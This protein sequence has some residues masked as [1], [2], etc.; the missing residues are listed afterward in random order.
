MAFFKRKRTKSGS[1]WT[2][3][4][5]GNLTRS[6][7][8]TKGRQR[9]TRSLSL[10]NGFTRSTT[11]RIGGWQ[12]RRR[13]KGFF[14]PVGWLM[15]AG[16]NAVDSAITPTE[17]THEESAPIS[18]EDI[19]AYHGK[20]SEIDHDLAENARL[21]KK[22]EGEIETP[23]GRAKFEAAKRA[24]MPKGNLF[25]LFLLSMFLMTPFIFWPIP[26][27]YWWTHRWVTKESDELHKP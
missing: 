5:A 22:R 15:A 25:Y 6:T 19:R 18:Q 13:K 26:I 2:A 7:S 16:C 27:Y 21:L 10:K 20:I 14:D 1:M 24:A 11:L 4:T 23:E 8:S 17:E 9:S 3:S 12:M